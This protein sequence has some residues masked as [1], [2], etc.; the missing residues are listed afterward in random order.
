MAL[1]EIDRYWP[2]LPTV[3]LGSPLPPS[4][5]GK[6]IQPR[7]PLGTKLPPLATWIPYDQEP[8]SI[9]AALPV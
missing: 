2:G 1:D 3:S 9:I 4:I 7:P 5:G 8:C 6:F